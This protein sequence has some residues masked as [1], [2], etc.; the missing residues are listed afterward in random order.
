MSRSWPPIQNW[1]VSPVRGGWAVQYEG[2]TFAGRHPIDVFR[3]VCQWLDVNDRTYNPEEIKQML[4]GVW[5]KRDPARW[6]GP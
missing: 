6:R 2:R 1:R 5:K 4:E 3:A